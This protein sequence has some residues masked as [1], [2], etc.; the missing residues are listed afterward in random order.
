MKK[1][2]ILHLSDEEREYLTGIITKGKP[3]ADKIKPA[4][5]LLNADADGPN[6]TAE[7]IAET[8]SVHK[9]TVSGVRP[10]AVEEGIEAALNR[11]KPERPPCLPKFDG[12]TEAKRIALRCGPP[13]GYARW[14]LRLLAETVVE[15]EILDSVSDE[16][17]R[18]TLKKN[19]LKPHLRKC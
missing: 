1:K 14:T 17:V 6:R 3:A 10:R 15:L 19:E 4:H 13:A 18:Q 5:I 11:Q 12:E 2:Y 8:F 7:R 9:N 16:T